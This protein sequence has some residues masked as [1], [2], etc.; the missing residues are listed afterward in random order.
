[1]KKKPPKTVAGTPVRVVGEPLLVRDERS[2]TY[3]VFIRR[4]VPFYQTS[5]SVELFVARSESDPTVEV[6]TR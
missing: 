3:L 2:P 4:P 6:L 5:C 1:M